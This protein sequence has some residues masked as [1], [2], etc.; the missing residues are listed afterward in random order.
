M[1]A[2]DY[3]SGER[4]KKKR[5]TDSHK[6]LCWKLS[7]QPFSFFFFFFLHFHLEFSL[8]ETSVAIL[9]FIEH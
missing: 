4:R 1:D 6:N 7:T 3:P 5:V 9:A 8:I 2:L